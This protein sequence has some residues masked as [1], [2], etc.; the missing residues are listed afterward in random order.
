[1]IGCHRVS[2]KDVTTIAHSFGSLTIRSI[3]DIE[4]D[5]RYRRGL[6][7]LRPPIT[8]SLL[9]SRM[10]KDQLLLKPYLILGKHVKSRGKFFEAGNGEELLG[11]RLGGLIR[12]QIA[13]NGAPQQSFQHILRLGRQ[14]P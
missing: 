1:M 10:S 3:P 14:Q 11:R 5:I 2:L 8:R 9:L 4:F 7:A 13:L 6:T 12:R